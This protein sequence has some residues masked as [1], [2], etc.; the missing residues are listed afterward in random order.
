MAPKTRVAQA[1]AAAQAAVAA[2]APPAASAGNHALHVE[3]QAAL[4]MIRAHPTFA[5]VVDLMPANIDAKLKERCGREAPP[6][7]A[8]AVPRDSSLR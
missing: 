6:A 4:A 3:V 1:A 7:A 8:A 5:G 2:A